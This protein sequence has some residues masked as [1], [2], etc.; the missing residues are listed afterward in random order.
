MK[1]FDKKLYNELCAKFL[2]Y[3]Y[4]GWNNPEHRLIDSKQGYWGLE[5]AKLHSLK[6]PNSILHKPLKFDSDW[7]MIM[8]VWN[9]MWTTYADKG[10]EEH[11]EFQ[12]KPEI[13][14]LQEIG[15]CCGDKEVVLE[16]IW[17]FLNK[18]YNDTK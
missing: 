16:C 4:Y 2:G 15:L 8:K 3:R 11:K 13:R 17:E 18:Y 9:K 5:D 12:N 1:T 7:N 14:M 6:I 10:L